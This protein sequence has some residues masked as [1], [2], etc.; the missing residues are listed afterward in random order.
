M[1]KFWSNQVWKN[2]FIHRLKRRYID[3]NVASLIGLPCH[4]YITDDI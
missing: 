4:L 3:E 2:R 1:Y